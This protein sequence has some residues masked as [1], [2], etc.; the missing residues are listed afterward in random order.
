MGVKGKPCHFV[1]SRYSFKFGFSKPRLLK[2]FFLTPFSFKPGGSA[3]CRMWTVS[4]ALWCVL[5]ELKHMPMHL[6]YLSI[7]RILQCRRA[8]L[9]T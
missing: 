7:H 1:R 6:H 9:A 4:C 2:S 8:S 3:P 5:A